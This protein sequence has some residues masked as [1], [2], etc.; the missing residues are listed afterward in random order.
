[1]SCHRHTYCQ[2]CEDEATTWLV[3]IWSGVVI[4]LLVLAWVAF[5]A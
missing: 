1:V 3:F 5:T 2:G 4:G